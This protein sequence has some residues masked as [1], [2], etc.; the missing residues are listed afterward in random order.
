[1][2]APE[3]AGERSGRP[4]RDGQGSLVSVNVGLPKDVPWQGKTVY[5]GAWKEPVP[6]PAMVRRLNI[7]GDGQGDLNGHGGEQRAVLVYQL[8]SYAYWRQHLGRDDLAWGNFGENLTVDGLPDDEV[9]IGDRYRIG[10]AEFEVTQPRVT[11]YRVGLRLGAP[12]LP[13]LLVSQHRPG[14]YMRVLAEG[15]IQAG[16]TIVRTRTGPQALTVAD[17]DA[18][19]YL[20]GRETARLRRATQIPALSPGWQQSFRDLLAAAEGS[21]PAGAGPATPAAPAWA[22]FR[23]LQVTRI[24]A[25][26]GT[27]SSI[28]LAAADG[29]ALP[30]A[31]PGQYLTVRVTGAADPAPVRS[32]SLSS[33][34]GAGDYRISVKREPHGVASTYLD[35]AVRAGAVLPAAAPRGD[36]TLVPGRGPVLLISAGI[37]VTPVLAMLHQLAAAGS[38]RDTW[39][40]HASR[41]PQEHPMAAEAHALLAALPHARER[42]FYSQAT[43][44]ERRRARATAGRLTKDA[45]AALAVPSD[46]DA[47]VCGPDSFMTEIRQALADAGLGPGRIHSELFGA[48]AAINPG[49]TARP[50]RLPHQPPGPPGTG[51]KVTFARSGIT[52]AFPAAGGSVL[53]L[54]DACDVPTRWSCRTGVCHTCVTPL[55]SGQVSYAPEPLEPPAGGQVLICCARPDTDVVLD[56]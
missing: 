43:P 54:A 8:A 13:A 47:Y 50:A 30:A 46:A 9:C 12:E 28:Y 17:A 36:F 38:E 1:M 31:L 10:E 40:I 21:G 23:P 16:D 4:G 24:V 14:F 25:E 22:G 7:D 44:A 45:L 42:I 56:M 52:T 15:R 33:V 34:P 2:A 37:G 55:L 5:T 48:L 29:T 11:C 53:D 27:V 32:Y 19:L 3:R 35:S 41:R 6:G 18:L 20:P 26:T 49:L 39:W 51:P